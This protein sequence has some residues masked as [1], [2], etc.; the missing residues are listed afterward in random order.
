M[1]ALQRPYSLVPWLTGVCRCHYKMLQDT[2]CSTHSDVN[3]STC[4]DPSQCCRCGREIP[5]PRRSQPLIAAIAQ[6][7][8]D[9]VALLCCYVGVSPC[10]L[11]YKKLLTACQGA[12]RK[13]THKVECRPSENH[14]SL[15]PTHAWRWLF[16]AR[17]LKADNG[18]AATL[19][20]QA[21][22]A[23]ENKI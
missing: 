17:Q 22:L 19:R 21:R 6:H 1:H 9:V 20:M 14:Q 11:L 15:G 3:S 7:C 5:R 13:P 12:A 23:S 2:H 4:E 16:V 8:T 18:R 10:I